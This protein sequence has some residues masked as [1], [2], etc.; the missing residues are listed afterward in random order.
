[1]NRELFNRSKRRMYS[2]IA[3][4]AP[5]VMILEEAKQLLALGAEED[6]EEIAPTRWQ[7]FRLWWLGVCGWPDECADAIVF[8]GE[9]KSQHRKH[10]CECQKITKMLTE[11]LRGVLPREKK[12]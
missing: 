2:F 12:K 8:D 9:K 4:D 6:E 11:A 5:D 10:G 1:M 7:S 3:M